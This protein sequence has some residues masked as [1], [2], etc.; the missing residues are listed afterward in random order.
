MNSAI[1]FL[2]VEVSAKEMDD[3][4]RGQLVWTHWTSGAADSGAGRVYWRRDPEIR[5][6]Y[7][8]E[9][10]ARLEGLGADVSWCWVFDYSMGIAT[11]RAVLGELAGRWADCV[12]D[13]DVG[14][15]L[16]GAAYAARVAE[17]PEWNWWSA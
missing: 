11:I 14:S 17:C 2:P 10:W 1:V 12:I 16:T 4:V 3:A 13:L 9:F 5:V 15:P 6:Q 8:D 7:A